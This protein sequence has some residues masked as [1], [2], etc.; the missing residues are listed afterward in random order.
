VNSDSSGKAHKHLG[1]KNLPRRLLAQQCR[2]LPGF[3]R[4]V[5]FLIRWGSIKED[6]LPERQQKL[7]VTENAPILSLHQA[8][9]IYGLPGYS[10]GSGKPKIKLS[11]CLINSTPCHEDVWGSGGMAPPFLTSTRHGGKWSAFLMEDYLYS[12]KYYTR[13]ESLPWWFLRF[14]RPVL[15]E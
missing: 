14:S 2:L 12:G 9:Y 15:G 1:S 4:A 11:L 7:L 8:G 13:F 3:G 5:N 6:S 10:N